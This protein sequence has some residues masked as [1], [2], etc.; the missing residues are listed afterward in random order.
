MLLAM[1]NEW[2]WTLFAKIYATVFTAELVGDRTLFAVGA[3]AARWRPLP[4]FLGTLPALGA[5]ALV[6]VLFGSAVAQLPPAFVATVSATTF[7][8]AAATI[9]KEPPAGPSAPGSASWRGGATA[10]FLAVLLTEWADVGQL[11]TAALAA[12]SGLPL[13]VWLGAVL[14]MATKSLVATT[15]GRHLR[16]YLSQRLVRVSAAAVCASIAILSA[17]RV[18]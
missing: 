1:N 5:K 10:A 17:L 13:V 14:A 12:S 16:R 9:W 6:A 11:A 3:M 4:V 7:L 8:L 15:L 18:D 2:S